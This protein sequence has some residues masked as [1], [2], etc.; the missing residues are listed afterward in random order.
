MLGIH[1]VELVVDAGEHFG[2]GR[3]VGDHAHGTLDA[4]K[5]ATGDDGRG[6]VVDTALEAGGAPVD[7]LDGALGLDGGDSSVDIL[8]DDITTVHEAASHVLAVAGIALGHH[9]GGFEGRVGDLGDGELLVVGLLS[10]D[11]GG[12]GGKHEVDTRVGDKVGLELS[13]VH[14][15]GTIETKGGSEGGDDLSDEAVQVGVGW[16]LD[17]EGTAADIVDGLVVKHDSNV[18]VLEERVGGEHGVVGLDNSGGNLG[19]R[20]DGETELG[21]AAVVDGKSLEEEGTKAGTGTTAYGVEDHETLEAGAV[22]G[23]LADAVKDEVNDFLADGVV[24]TGV[25]VGGVFL[26]GDNLFRVVELAVSAGADFVTHGGLEVNVDGA[27]HVLAGTGLG[28]EG[29][30][31]IVTTA[32]STTPNRSSPAKKMQ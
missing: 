29:V 19:R 24:T 30:E 25:V 27:G 7:E 8:G 17:I 6:L 22:I 11:D 1:K 26:A 21:L 5:I 28:E 20:V 14:V 15:E 2:D 16:A 4:G 3:G 23:E 32:G 10:R 18:G 9:G 12:V 31:S 13:D